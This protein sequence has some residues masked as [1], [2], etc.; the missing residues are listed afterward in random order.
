MMILIRR[1]VKIMMV[2]VYLLVAD[3]DDNDPLNA[4]TF[5]RLF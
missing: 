5:G 4:G 3:C 2:M 1:L